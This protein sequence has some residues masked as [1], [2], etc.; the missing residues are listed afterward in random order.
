MSSLDDFGSRISL[1]VLQP[2]TKA[3][4][5]GLRALSGVICAA[6]RAKRSSARVMS[7]A[8]ASTSAGSSSHM[9]PTVRHETLFMYIRYMSARRNFPLLT[10]WLKP[11]LE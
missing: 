3:R 8:A 1:M 7:L 6:R 11:P 5:N 10:S 4:S 9:A 2:L